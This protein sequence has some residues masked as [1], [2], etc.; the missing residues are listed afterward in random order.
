MYYY[1]LYIKK[2]EMSEETRNSHKILVRKPP[3]KKPLGR[4]E[5]RW[6]DRH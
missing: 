4:P 3:R 1:G 2:D 5:R 6:E